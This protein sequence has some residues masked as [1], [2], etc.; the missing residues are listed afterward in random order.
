MIFTFL[1]KKKSVIHCVNPIWGKNSEIILS[2]LKIILKIVPQHQSWKTERISTKNSRSILIGEDDIDDQ[3]FLAEVF[4]S[5]DNS[6][7]LT[8]A[9]NGTKVLD[10]LR[11]CKKNN[12]PCLILL[13]YNM[14]GKNG[15]EILKELNTIDSYSS[16][17]KIIWSTSKSQ[18]YKDICLQ[19][20]ARDYVI[21]PSTVND[22]I[23][24]ANYLLSFTKI[25]NTNV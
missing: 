12:L 15:A 4:S 24:L 16:I 17:P 10:Y 18:T 5:V 23:E 25:K 13:D 14:P 8:F 21:K 9:A 11:K 20:G 1:F 2:Y 7:E 3:E 19:L 22:F 6:F